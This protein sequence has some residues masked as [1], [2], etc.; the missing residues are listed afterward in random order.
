[1]TKRFFLFVLLAFFVYASNASAQANQRNMPYK[2]GESLTYEGK[3]KKIGFAFS[4]AELNFTVAK[5]PQTKYFLIKSEAR[6]KGTLPRIAKMFNFEFFQLYKST[7]D[8]ENLQILETTKRDEQGDRVR[9]SRADFNYS[10]RKVTYVETDPKDS[11]RPPRIVASTIG[12]DTQDIISAIY[13]LRG[14]PLAVGETFVMK[15]SDSGLVY[16]VPVRVAARERKKSILGKKWC[17]RIEPEIFGD[18]RF[19]EQKGSLV[20]WITDDEN[21]VPIRAEIETKIGDITIK[22]EKIKTKDL[23]LERD[24]KDDDDDDDTEDETESKTD[25]GDARGN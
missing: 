21:R 5:I 6:S 16:D 18:G 2:E 20:L 7:V 25:T 10:N 11:A 8:A 3:L 15:I 23:N 17:F 12:A 14:M 19:I 13:R 1:M 22:L 9:D 24:G 4:V